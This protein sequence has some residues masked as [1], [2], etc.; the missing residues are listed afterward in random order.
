MVC[1][2]FFFSG[3]VRIFFW[4]AI[5]GCFCFSWFA[6]C[7][8]PWFLF[9][10][11]IDVCYLFFFSGLQF[12]V[13][14]GCLVFGFLWFLVFCF[15][16]LWFLFSGFLVYAFLL[17]FWIWVWVWVPEFVPVL[18][19]RCWHLR[20]LSCWPNLS[21]EAQQL[22]QPWTQLWMHVLDACSYLS[23]KQ[24]AI[25]ATKRQKKSTIEQP[26]QKPSRSSGMFLMSDLIWSLTASQHSHPMTIKC[27]SRA[28]FEWMCSV[29][30]LN[31]LIIGSRRS[32]DRCGLFFWMP[33][34]DHPLK[35]ERH[36]ED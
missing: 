29:L 20:G 24:Q 4:F 32:L 33:F 28:S 12:L 14:S 23:V 35:L 26:S 36:R 22:A 7:F 25:T 19:G 5:S 16:V 13:V 10:F 27:R 17:C 3:L 31:W 6:I 11:A 2:F 15:L 30:A 8:F 9:C 1:I 34:V 18:L 21:Q